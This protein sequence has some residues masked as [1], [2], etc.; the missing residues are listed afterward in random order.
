MSA[1]KMEFKTEMKQLMDIIVNSLYTHRDI[2]LRELISNASDAI[3]AIR[4]ESL[5]KPEITGDDSDWKI[6]IIPDKNS[7]TLT[8][9]DNGCGMSRK[10]IVDNLGTIARSGTRRLMEKIKKS[11]AENRPDLIGQFGVGFYSALMV[12]DSIRVVSR[13]AG[14][15]SQAVVWETAGHGDFSVDTAKKDSRGTEIVLK[16]KKDAL[17]FLDD[18]KI[19]QVVKTYSDFIEYPIELLTTK[20]EEG[21]QVPSRDKLNSRQAIWIK[22]KDQVS[23]EEYEEFYKHLTH[24][25]EAPLETIH[26][27]AEGTIEF[28]ALLYVPAHRPLD[29]FWSMEKKGLSLY[30]NRVFIMDN[31]DKLI[32]DYLRFIRGVVDSADLP[33]NVSRE[34]LQQN[35]LLTKIKKNLVSKILSALKDMKE[36]EFEKY[37]KFY[38]N[39]GQSL[40]EGLQG[41]FENSDKLSS[42]LLYQ[43]TVTEPSKYT[44][45]DK[46]V[47]SMKE[48]QKEIYYLVGESRDLLQNSPYLEV[49]RSRGHEVLLMTDPMDEFLAQSL[50]TYRDKPLKAVDKGEFESPTEDSEVSD[51]LKGLFEALTEKI[52]EVS[53]VRKSSR[54]KD[55]ASCLVVEENQMGAHVENLMKKLGREDELTKANRILE[56][57]AGHPVVVS[58]AALH[59]KNPNDERI[60]R[61]GRILYEQAVL[62]EGS[63]LQNPADFAG[64]LN[65]MIIELLKG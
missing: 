65:Q 61:F 50:G 64:R 22:S 60:A 42:L 35:L 11:S 6:E 4:F 20:E 7:G 62:A 55:S 14:K 8:I 34:M 52:D 28:K 48:D 46:Y 40:K 29:Y 51:G 31:C 58:L 2:F 57:N 38:E 21:K 25:F 15:N 44:T 30:I 37:V 10:T 26:Y 36:K 54:L 47:D 9:R 49:F 19:R 23:G 24:D 27:S 41:D 13:P 17:E 5:T 1:E 45:L 59:E 32:P 18:W 53:G 16:L 33:L 63:K 39:F 56:L 3:D 43:S 12:A